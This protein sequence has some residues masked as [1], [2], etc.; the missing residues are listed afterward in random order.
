MLTITV[1]RD[2]GQTVTPEISHSEHKSKRQICGEIPVY[3]ALAVR[4]TRHNF[5]SGLV[6]GDPARV[7]HVRD[8]PLDLHMIRT[9]PPVGRHATPVLIRAQILVEA[10]VKILARI[11][12]QAPVKISV[13]IPARIPA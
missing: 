2:T 10:H 9:W 5:L 3:G 1:R 12:A 6:N 7:R 11:P 13:K 8:A 4:T